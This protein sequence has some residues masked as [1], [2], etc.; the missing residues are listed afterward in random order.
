MF[1]AT[2]GVAPSEGKALTSADRSNGLR[3][4]AR[5]SAGIFFKPY[6]LAG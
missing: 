6:P 1:M 5:L 3:Q 4:C 2:R